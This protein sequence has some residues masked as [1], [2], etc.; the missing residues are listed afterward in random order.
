MIGLL[1]VT[2]VGARTVLSGVDAVRRSPC[3][4]CR[5][6]LGQPGRAAPA[7]DGP[8]AGLVVG[9]PGRLHARPARRR[10][11]RGRTLVADGGRRRDA[12]ATWSSTWSSSSAR[13][14]RG[15]AAR[16]LTAARG[17]LP[18]AARRSPWVGGALVVCPDRAGRAAAGAG[19][20]VRQGRGAALGAARRRR[21]AGGR[22]GG[23]H[24]HRPGVLPARWP[25][26]RSSAA[27]GGTPAP[28]L[29]L[30]PVAGGGRR[31][32]RWSSSWCSA[33]PRSV[34][35]PPGLLGG[36]RAGPGGRWNRRKDPG[37]ER[38]P[39]SDSSTG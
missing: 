8:A 38:L 1:L 24:G 37:Q 10:S 28:R 12:S 20:A 30:R 25:R 19:R 29:R 6:D 17:R 9:G 7:A 23:Q 15:R 14:P 26:P 33:S 27:P 32:A 34:A 4:R 21:L 11:A 13:S 22:G 31:C 35:A 36:T 5:D 18:R 2:T 16:A 39:C 3:W